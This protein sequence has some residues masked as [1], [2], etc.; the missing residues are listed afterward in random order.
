MSCIEQ[1]IERTAVSRKK[2]GGSLSMRRGTRRKGRTEKQLSARCS[3]EGKLCQILEKRFEPRRV[4]GCGVACE[5]R[6]REKERERE[7]EG[8]EIDVRAYTGSTQRASMETEAQIGCLFTEMKQSPRADAVLLLSPRLSQRPSA[9]DAFSITGNI[10][11]CN[12]PPGN[13]NLCGEM[14]RRCLIG[15]S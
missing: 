4:E 11:C 10:S 3:L 1:R 13:R 8:R 15:T 6:E 5:R 2:S 9:I 12:F 7:R 14:E